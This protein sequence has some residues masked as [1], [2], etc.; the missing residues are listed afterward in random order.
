LLQGVPARRYII[1]GPIISNERPK[2]TPVRGPAPS[3]PTALGVIRVPYLNYGP[4]GS[5]QSKFM[6]FIPIPDFPKK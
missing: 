3:D 4:S 1:R 6:E 5:S 2:Q